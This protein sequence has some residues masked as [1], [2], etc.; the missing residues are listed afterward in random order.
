MRLTSRSM[1]AS[2][3][4]LSM[5]S[6]VT[7]GLISRAAMSNTSRPKRQTFRIASCS[8]LLRMVIFLFAANVCSSISISSWID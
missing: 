1:Q 7:P 4:I 2:W 8:F 6:V 5:W 3:T